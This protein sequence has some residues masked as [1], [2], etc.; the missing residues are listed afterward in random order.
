[1]EL[2]PEWVDAATGERARWRAAWNAPGYLI[3]MAESLIGSSGSSDEPPVFVS[4]MK[5]A[6]ALE[7]AEQ[8][9]SE[10]RVEDAYRTFLPV[11][12]GDRQKGYINITALNND[13][14]LEGHVRFMARRPL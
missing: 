8:D 11:L 6:E 12:K 10:G 4:L 2:L 14:E 13:P 1:M 9:L 3:A 7:K 5:S